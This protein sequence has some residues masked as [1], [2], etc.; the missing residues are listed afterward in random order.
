MK[1]PIQFFL[2]FNSLL[3]VSSPNAAVLHVGTGQPF[4]SLENAANVANPGDT[5]MIHEGTYAGGLYIE[6]LQGTNDDWIVITAVEGE[7]VIYEGGNNAWQFTDGAYLEING[8]TFQHQLGN[9]LNFDDG[10]TY[11]TPTH[12]IRFINCTFR[13]MNASGN[14]DLLKLSGLDFFEVRN[15]TFLNGAAGG[16][17][18]DMVGCHD[19]V[20]AGNYFENL[21]SN[22]VQAKGG[23]S[24][25]LIERNFFR[26]G[27]QRTLNLGGS[28]GLQFFRPIDAPYE[29]ARLYVYSNVFIGS[30]TPVAFVGCVDSEVINNTMYLPEKWP[31]RI[32]QETVDT[33]RFFPCGNNTYRNNINYLDQRVTVDCNIG[34]NTA[35]N[36]FTFSNNLWFH[37]DNPNWNGPVLPTA[38]LDNIVGEDPLFEDAGNEDFRISTNSPAIGEGFDVVD[39]VVDYNAIAF[40]SPRS[41]G[42]FEGDPVTSVADDERITEI[43]LF[44][45]PAEDVVYLK[46]TGLNENTF[47]KLYDVIGRELIVDY[48]M[49]EDMITL[50][51]TELINGLYLISVKANNPVIFVKQ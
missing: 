39:P 23:T 20:I 4:A 38:D 51:V 1:T 14:N 36:T 5:I 8:I 35:P 44:P 21:G 47:L 26:N 40:N 27:G 9:G 46:G 31:M 41:I 33:T 18:I 16:S 50:N 13:D 28:T 19:G 37:V 45:N 11:E 29:A 12:H 49:K 10:G 7:T 42:A 34:P 6:N 24:D 22:C 32:L 48:V 3:L 17:G 43:S 30:V 15:C 2:L 25:I